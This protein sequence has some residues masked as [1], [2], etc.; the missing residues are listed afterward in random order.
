[1]DSMDRDSAQ[2]RV[3][4]LVLTT[5]PE[6]LGAVLEISQELELKEQLRAFVQHA[7]GWSAAWGG[8]GF[9]PG[10]ERNLLAPLVHLPTH[11]ER[12][13]PALSSIERGLVRQWLEGEQR[14]FAGL[15]PFAASL[16]TPL[17]GSPPGTALA[18]P[19]CADDG[20]CTALVLLFFDEAPPA[21]VLERIERLVELAAPAVRNA[22]AVLSIRELV[23]RDDTAHC[24]NRRYFE[25]SLPEELSRAGRF[26]SPLS[27]I[28][29]DMD[30]L[31]E[32]NRRHGHAMGS[33]TLLE[34]SRRVR[35]K[36]RRFDK[37]FRFGGDE[38]CIILPETDWHGALEVAERVRD[39][40][41]GR[42]FLVHE[43]GN[44]EGARMTASLGI[45]SYPLHARNKQD[46]VEQADRAMQRIKNATKNSIG[47]AE[48]VGGSRDG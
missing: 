5:D 12:Q 1:M 43:L 2:T 21:Q 16:E 47:I 20:E 46:L 18:L 17:A 38:F 42:P 30:N 15:G 11:P 22:L 41:A 24:F 34:V 31:K 44:P 45:A 6:L 28:F 9:G 23:I 8:V 3:R 40:I 13:L 39:A 33:R 19:F 4:P 10:G 7:G 37:L 27:L 48:I 25:T 35:A 14:Q 26:H 29:L 32:V 36:I